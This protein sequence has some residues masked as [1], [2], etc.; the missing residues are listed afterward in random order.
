LIEDIFLRSVE[1]ISTFTGKVNGNLDTCAFKDCISAIICDYI[2]RS[3]RKNIPFELTRQEFEDLQ[4]LPCYLC[5]KTCSAFHRNGVDRVNNNIGYTL[6]NCKPCCK[7]CNWMK[8]TY[9]LDIF[10][11]KLTKIYHYQNMKEK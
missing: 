2:N 4:K 8:G 3:K 1:H 9:S 5:G 11:D 6:D 10:L 7:Q